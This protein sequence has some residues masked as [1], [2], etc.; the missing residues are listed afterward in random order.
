MDEGKGERE[1][2]E[3]EYEG[4]R[5][6]EEMG[7]GE[8]KI[9]KGRG[10]ERRKGRERIEEGRGGRERDCFGSPPLPPPPQGL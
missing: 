10:E 7:E 3:L 1:G 6:V 8:E 4:E 9:I 5:R 2:S